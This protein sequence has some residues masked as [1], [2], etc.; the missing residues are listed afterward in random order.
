V[1]FP[2]KV[3]DARGSLPDELRVC[4]IKEAGDCSLGGEE[5][6]MSRLSWKTRPSWAFVRAEFAPFFGSIAIYRLVPVTNDF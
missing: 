6:G 3:R 2:L 5:L 4:C 1:L